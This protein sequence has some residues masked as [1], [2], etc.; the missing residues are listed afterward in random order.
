M[1]E[2]FLKKLISFETAT[3]KKEENA[4]ALAWVKNELKG[5]PLY[6]KSFN[7][8]GHHSL[9]ATTKM[10]KRPK[11]WLQAHMDVVEGPKHL[12]KPAVKNGRLY[13]RGAFDMKFAIACYMRFLKEVNKEL[14]KYSLGI[15][16][17]SDE[18]TGGKS[19]VAEILKKGYGAKVCFLP[20]GGENWRMEEAAKGVYRLKVES[21]G[22]PA[23]SSRPWEGEN[24]IDNLMEYLSRIKEYFPK[25]PCGIADHSHNTCSINLIK[26]G[27]SANKMP[28]LA[29][30]FVDVR[31]IP[32]TK[33]EDIKRIFVLVKKDFPFIKIKEDSVFANS[34]GL[35]RDN[36]YVRLFCDL[37]QNKFNK[38]IDFT[39]SHGSSDGRFF[40]A[41]KI[42]AIILRPKGGGHHGPEEWVDLR[43]LEDFYDV[44]KAFSLKV[45]R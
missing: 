15:M 18:E 20:D 40:A 39:I 38:K 44:F 19:G 11:L 37:A 2:K 43:D 8:N 45:S 16:L 29:E 41:K 9:I 17:T 25:E 22:V 7:I 10:T 12:F 14:K 36:K 26:G 33:K 13:G 27:E 42:P 1:H 31:F 5:L 35:R 32:K 34:Y 30:A 6:F 4:R 24:A 28:E 3:H 21:L 23:H